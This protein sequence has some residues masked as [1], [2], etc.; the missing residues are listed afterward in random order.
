DKIHNYAKD[1]LA[2]ANEANLIKGMSDGTLSPR[3]EATREQFA[4]ILKRFDDTFT[5]VYNEPVP[6]SQ[7]TEPEYPLVENADVYVAVNGSDS[8][9]GTFDAPVATFNRAVELVR[10]IKQ[11]KTTGDIIVAFKAG[12][13]GPLSLNLTAGDSGTPEQRIVYCKYGD[14]DV[15]FS[16]GTLL[17]AEDFE[18]ISEEEKGLFRSGTNTDLIKKTY[19]GDKISSYKV[20]DTFFTDEN[21]L[22]VARFPNK[23]GDGSDQLIRNCR[24]EDSHHIRVYQRPM[25]DRI[26][27]YHTTEGLILYGY[28]TYGWYKDYV[29]IGGVEVE[30]ETGD[31]ILYVP[32]PEN[33]RAGGLRFEP[34]FQ[35][36]YFTTALLNVSEELDHD[37]EYF[38]DMST[39]TMYVFGPVSNIYILRE[40]VAVTM[41]HADYITFLGIGITDYNTGFVKATKCHGITFDRCVF[42]RC[43]GE[44]PIEFDGAD[45]GR[46]LD[47]L[48]TGCTFSTFSYRVISIEGENSTEH[49]FDHVSN[50]VIENNYI[51]RTNLIVDSSGAVDVSGC[52]GPVVAHNF[53]EDCYRCAVIFCGTYEMRAEYNVF[54][55]CMCNSEDG[56]IFYS[57]ANYPG[58]Y[59]DWGNR[60]CHNLFYHTGWY[61]VYQDEGEPGAEIYENLFYGITEPVVDHKGRSNTVRDNYF[62]NPGGRVGISISLEVRD[63]ILARIASGEGDLADTPGYRGWL[64]LFAFYDSHPEIKAEVLRRAPW[65]FELTTD[66][67]MIEDRNFVGNPSDVI[68]GNCV[69]ATSDRTELIDLEKVGRF[70]TY[71]NNRFFDEKENPC[72]VN[73]TAGDYRVRA[74]V[75]GFPDLQFEQIG[76]Y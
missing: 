71:E 26:K 13:Y 67:T 35:T 37:G 23:Y 68:T 36:G 58:G 62:V 29:E 22:T 76:R 18:P 14:G 65:V 72:F 15:T 44:S 8:N 16:G 45:I 6:R 53:F 32:H 63:A 42:R 30:G 74:G 1:A 55:R 19:V 38:I 59:D 31:C 3:G 41:D 61:A 60:I 49:R 48:I 11:T 27:T 46:S 20:T 21:V 75:E 66:P 57:V 40:E 17:K 52:A 70:C 24:T 7:Y 9:T 50:P 73:P 43:A 34:W 54:L 10:E 69:L 56:G 33:T 25:K 51:G 28:I 4:T 12:D 5:L 2:W 39:G 47:L 64:R